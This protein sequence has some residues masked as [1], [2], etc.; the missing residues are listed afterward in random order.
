MLNSWYETDKRVFCHAMYFDKNL[1]DN[2]AW[3]KH[4]IRKH[5]GYVLHTLINHIDKIVT[6]YFVEVI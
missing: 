6:V 4:Q 5:S 1:K 2:I 3:L